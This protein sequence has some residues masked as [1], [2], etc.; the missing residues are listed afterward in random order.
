VTGG[1]REEGAYVR[2]PRQERSRRTLDAIVRAA[3]DLLEE[4]AFDDLTVDRIVERAGSSKGSFY[5]RFPDK[6]SLLRFL[7]EDEFGRILDEWSRFLAPERWSD[8]SL[9]TFASTLVER[10]VRI[11]R[12]RGA[13]TR[14]FIREMR[15]GEDE[16]IRERGARLNRHVH[17]R[18]VALAERWRED[19]DHPEPRLAAGL[20]LVAVAAAARSAILY[21]E[22]GSNPGAVDDATLARELTRMYLLYLGADPV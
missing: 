14:A 21:E 15:T 19:I 18:V 22:E 5:A 10:L 6:R 1:A 2:E 8:A 7:A 3:R 13:E 12:E 17:D 11:Y 4:H 16:A 20:G 9:E